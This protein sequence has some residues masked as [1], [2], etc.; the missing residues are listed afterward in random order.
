MHV[1]NP[2]ITKL[3]PNGDQH[4]KLMLQRQLLHTSES[5]NNIIVTN[6]PGIPTVR[7]GLHSEI[8]QVQF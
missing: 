2:L 1:T 4:V 8:E 7:I 5:G 3:R 6:R